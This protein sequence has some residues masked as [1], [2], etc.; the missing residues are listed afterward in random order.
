[1]RW[2][3]IDALLVAM[4]VLFACSDADRF[5]SAE[6]N[7]KSLRTALEAFKADVGRYPTESEGLHAL[8][9]PPGLARWQGPYLRTTFPVGDFSYKC[10]NCVSPEL[11][12]VHHAG[13]KVSSPK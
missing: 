2:L 6:V 8:I 5:P 1:M 4:I 11:T 7:T 13:P 12:P 10:D 3:V 9:N